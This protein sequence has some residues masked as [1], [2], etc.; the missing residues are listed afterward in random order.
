M[1]PFCSSERQ[2]CLLLVIWVDGCHLIY[3]HMGDAECCPHHSLAQLL[4]VEAG[5]SKQH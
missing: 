3:M 2:G 1:L 4:C 5:I